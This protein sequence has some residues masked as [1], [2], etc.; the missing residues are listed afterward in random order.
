MHEV[1]QSQSHSDTLLE[2]QKDISFFLSPETWKKALSLGIVLKYI[3]MK[4]SDSDC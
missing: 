4:L 3:N 1:A 2:I